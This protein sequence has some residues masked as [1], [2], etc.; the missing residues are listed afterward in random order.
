M[1][2]RNRQI[3]IQTDRQIERQR[4]RERESVHFQL[5]SVTFVAMVTKQAVIPLMSLWV[6]ILCLWRWWWRRIVSV[7]LD[8]FA[9]F[10]IVIVVVLSVARRRHHHCFSAS[11]GVVART[12]VVVIIIII[13]TVYSVDDAVVVDSRSTREP[14]EGLQSSSSSTSLRILTPAWG[15]DATV[16]WLGSEG[17]KRT[18]QSSIGMQE[19]GP[20]FEWS[21]DKSGHLLVKMLL[22]GCWGWWSTGVWW[23]VRRR[24]GSYFRWFNVENRRCI[25]GGGFIVAVDLTRAALHP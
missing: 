23:G 5:S 11:C 17:C 10:I 19:D 7:P 4:Q 21:V 16:G 12:A 8:D 22:I 20:I 14:S 15:I 6:G 2:P 24:L 25:D 1:E 3:Y 9:H 18:S 13:I